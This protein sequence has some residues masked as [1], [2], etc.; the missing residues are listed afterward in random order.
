MDEL[1]CSRSTLHRTIVHLRDVLGAPVIN[2]HGSGYL[3][4]R[5]AGKFELPG[6]WFRA[7]ELEALL[8]MEHLLETV[9]PGMLDEHM[10]PLRE[11]VRELLDRG[12]QGRT[13]FPTH[14]IR[15]LRSHARPVSTAKLVAVAAT[16]VERRQLA[17][18]YAGRVAG[19]TSRRA[20]SPQR[21][22][23]YRDQWY[24][25][26]WD[27]AK[28]ALRTF[29]IDR[30]QDVEAQPAGAREVPEDELDAALT[31]GYG[32]FAGAAKETARLRFTA[33]RARWVADET[34]H[35]E[36]SGRFLPDGRYELLVPYA[37]DR[38]LV[39]EIL[40]HGPEVEVLGPDSLVEVVRERLAE[41]VGLY[42]GKGTD[43]ALGRCHFDGLDPRA[44][45][46]GD[47][48][49]RAFDAV[50]TK[51]IGQG[52]GD[53]LDDFLVRGCL[54]RNARHVVAGRYPRVGVAVPSGIYG[55]AGHRRRSRFTI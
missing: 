22:V 45:D 10:R 27:E 15:I 34:W 44:E 26:A 51:Y 12:V 2:A 3:Y 37:D 49:G 7:D 23:Y 43:G 30:M 18:T 46:H 24:L 38:E 50:G 28:D 8:V 11:K 1:E 32:L 4:D 14:R 17:F 39:G 55:V 6:L 47:A 21:L 20:V 52:I 48:G 29:A 13:P 9:Q 5:G 19:D 31:P 33:E 36:Q 54:Y 16:V 41:A 25:D 40:R 42:A 35:P 53:H